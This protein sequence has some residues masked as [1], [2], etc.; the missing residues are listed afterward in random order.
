MS[1][2]MAAAALRAENP[3]RTKMLLVRMGGSFARAGRFSTSLGARRYL[4]EGMG[5][6]KEVN[7]SHV[8]VSDYARYHDCPLHVKE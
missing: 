4:L 3:L 7:R 1:G 5:S 8:R 6:E 2:T